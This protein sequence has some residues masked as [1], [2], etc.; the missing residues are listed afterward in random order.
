MRM[1]KENKIWQ[2]MSNL[3]LFE[4]LWTQSISHMGEKQQVI[5]SF[6]VCWYFYF[7]SLRSSVECRMNFKCRMNCWNSTEV[8]AHKNLL[9]CLSF[10]LMRSLVFSRFSCHH[11]HFN[12][13]Y[14]SC[15][16]LKINTWLKINRAIRE[17]QDEK[18][19]WKKVSS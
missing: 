5:L 9:I 10:F 17:N 13:N 16:S 14:I 11:G 3:C 8:V 19:Y 12:N 7:F 1:K 2:T 4:N 6:V 15:N 18:H